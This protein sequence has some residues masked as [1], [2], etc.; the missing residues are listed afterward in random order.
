[1]PPTF[2]MGGGGH[3][4]LPLSVCPPLVMH[5]YFF[6]HTM[7]H[8]SHNKI[9]FAHKEIYFAHILSTKQIG[10]AVVECLTRG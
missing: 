9:H 3:I 8:F 1:M 7:V 6:S 2:S 10:S 5:E 4:A